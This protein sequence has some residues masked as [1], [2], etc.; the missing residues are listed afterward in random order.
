MAPEASIKGNSKDT[1][2]FL[3]DLK[4]RYRHL[5]ELERQLNALSDSEA[6]TPQGQALLKEFSQAFGDVMS[7]EAF[8]Q[9]LRRNGEHLLPS[10]PLGRA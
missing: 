9:D 3:Q 6:E 4:D 10:R 5:H 8:I 2:A 7:R 1:N